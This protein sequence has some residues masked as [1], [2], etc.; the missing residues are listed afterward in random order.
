MA[1]LGGYCD[2]P[3]RPHSCPQSVCSLEGSVLHTKKLCDG[4]LVIQLPFDQ[5]GLGHNTLICFQIFDST[6]RTMTSDPRDLSGSHKLCL[7]HIIFLRIGK[8]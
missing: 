6:S 8:L 5:A 2:E 4:S 1:A 7:V 3:Q